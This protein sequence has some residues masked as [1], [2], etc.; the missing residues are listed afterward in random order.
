MNPMEF[1]FCTVSTCPLNRDNQCRA[2]AINIGM[3]GSC[4]TKLADEKPPMSEIPRYVEIKSCLCSECDHW[5]SDP[6][7][8][9]CCSFAGTLNFEGHMSD[10]VKDPKKV[11]SE[12]RAVCTNFG[13]KIDQPAWQAI[14]PE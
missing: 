14:L 13:N 6:N 9:P 5:E 8:K 10:T 7:G 1:V 2:Q 3:D 4:L 12:G 11:R